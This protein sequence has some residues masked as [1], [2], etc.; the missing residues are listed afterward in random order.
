[1]NSGHI[2]KLDLETGESLAHYERNAPKDRESELPKIRN[3][4]L[5]E[6]KVYDASYNGLY[7]TDSGKEIDDRQIGSAEVYDSRLF[8]VPH[9]PHTKELDQKYISS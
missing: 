9:G 1:M 2:E 5:F 6:G 8:I 4:L 3:L 7:E